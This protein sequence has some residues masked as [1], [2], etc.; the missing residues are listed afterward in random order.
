MVVREVNW[1]QKE[2]KIDSDGKKVLTP[3]DPDFV[4]DAIVFTAQPDD[5]PC[6]VR[7]RERAR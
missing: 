1:M 3:K 5:P 4:E 6:V 2:N 7:S